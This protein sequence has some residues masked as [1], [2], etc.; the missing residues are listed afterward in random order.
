MLLRVTA[1][2]LPQYQM[3][4]FLLPKSWCKKVDSLFKNF[5]WGFKESDGH[6]YTPVAWSKIYVPKEWGGVGG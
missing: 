2:T 1:S 5:F 4:S 6:R 3:A